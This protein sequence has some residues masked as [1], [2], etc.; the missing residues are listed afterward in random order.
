MN[1]YEIDLAIEEA[2]TQ[3]VWKK[4]CGRVEKVSAKIYTEEVKW[5]E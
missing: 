1:L 4:M 3:A 5:D 2:F